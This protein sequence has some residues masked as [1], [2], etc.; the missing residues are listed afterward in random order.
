MSGM[1]EWVL[2]FG[3]GQ[4]G[5]AFEHGESDEGLLPDFA[6]RAIAN[7]RVTFVGVPI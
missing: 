2:A 6:D 7:R 1:Q 4:Y 3:P 5:D